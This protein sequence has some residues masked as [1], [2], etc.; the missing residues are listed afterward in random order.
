MFYPFLVSDP[1][2][3]LRF[4]PNDKLL[5]ELAL[6]PAELEWLPGKAIARI[7]EPVWADSLA[8]A[9]VET[10]AAVSSALA[11]LVVA[12]PNLRLPNLE[13]MPEGRARRH[14]LALAGIWREL[15]EAL[16]QG[17]G[18]VRHALE[19]SHGR[20]LSALPVV[21]GSLDPVAPAAMRALYYRLKSEFGTVPNQE[22][23]RLA[24]PGTRLHAVQGGLT[25]ATIEVG[26]RDG[27]ISFYGLR[28][29][30]ACANFAAARAR[31]M[32]E[33]GEPANSIAVMT[34]GNTRLLE[35][36]FAHQGVP[37]S[38][39]PGQLPK[40]DVLGETAL[41]LLLAKRSPTPSMVL[42]SLAL[43]PVMP[44]DP[45]IGRDL[46]ESLAGGDY[47]G[48]A[49]RDTPAHVAL[50]DDI[51]ASASSLSQLRFLIDRICSQ[52]SQGQALRELIAIPQVEGT[53][54]WD[55]LL[56][57]I[58]VGPHAIGDPVRN[59]EGV[60]IWNASES[61]W[62]PCSHL[63]V[64][65][66]TE[67]AYPSRPR[68]NPLFLDSEVVAVREATG[69]TLFGRAEGL[70]ASL[71]LFD[72]QIQAAAQSVTFLVPRRDLAGS[73]QA[74]SAGMSLMARVFDGSP[75]ASDLIVDLSTVPPEQWPISHHQPPP[76]STTSSPLGALDL[77]GRD[78]LALRLD[79]NGVAKPQSPSRLETLLVSPFAWLL[80]EL[81]VRDLS[82]A[83]EGL[84]VI[85]K[86]N[87][88]HDVF[89]NLFVPG[90]A[91][92]DATSMPETL[93]TI[94]DR[95]LGRHAGF[96][97]GSAWEMERRG[98]ESD[99]LQAALRWREH[100]VNLGAKI[101]GNEIWLAGTAHGVS[102]RGKADAILC[103]PD[104]SLLV[105]DHK[106]SGTAGRRK[107]MEAGWDLQAGLYRD[108]IARP[109]RSEGDGMDPLVGRRVGIGYH[110]MNDGGLLTSGFLPV[111]SST[112]RDMG[113]LINEGAVAKLGERLG[114]LK[115][116]RIVL[117]TTDDEAF[118]KKEA[119]FTPYALTDGLLLVR[120][121]VQQAV[122]EE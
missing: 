51:R 18:A 17:L 26:K 8:N 49:L 100:L 47:R 67:G 79:E 105:V 61:P 6:A 118:F 48:T 4:R 59:L 115:L 94:F 11:N 89:E 40:R 102:L 1:R 107:R 104:G 78:L 30:N 50:W 121:F 85:I 95:A 113:E 5:S 44:W 76:P 83:S 82:W 62:R 97:R 15:G 33:A 108:M 63:I 109:T 87:I 84:D 111:A 23:S 27:S 10:I 31:M 101:V 69:L 46:A 52:L 12:T 70:A 42:A 36:A 20:F 65:D 114:E 71:S 58:S 29:P 106:K 25:E 90:D 75:D 119:G 34:T 99:I 21:E 81:G 80:E 64:V 73:R 120:A 19:L 39:L 9:P 22:G 72:Q 110:L 77:S 92:P 98:L 38:G 55:G 24:A 88:A 37:L 45:Q 14:L 122:A 53:P 3:G 57:A 32:I 68:P 35:R 112:A 7:V 13:A 86:G 74:A 2:S 56:R 96:L 54:D 41:F 66:F 93:Q 117:N 103:M 43:S 91:F 116:G 16:P 60:S 28:D